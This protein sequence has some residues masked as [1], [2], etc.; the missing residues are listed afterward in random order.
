[1]AL[2]T[3]SDA[4]LYM[5][6]TTSDNDVLISDLIGQVS[7]MIENEL[8]SVIEATDFNNEPYNGVGDTYLYLENCDKTAHATANASGLIQS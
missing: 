2:T 3:L 5:G 7:V 8:G 1:M 4:K 6:I